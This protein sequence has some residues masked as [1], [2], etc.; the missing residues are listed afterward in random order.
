MEELAET[1]KEVGW[2]G[3]GEGREGRGGERRGRH[4]KCTVCR[5]DSVKNCLFN[6][7]FKWHLVC[8][9]AAWCA[10]ACVRGRGTLTKGEGQGGHTPWWAGPY[11]VSNDNLNL[12][13]LI[14][15]EALELV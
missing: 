13:L 14:G 3:A 7:S 12:V 6:T 5:T 15:D 9:C 11:S 10:S 2:A 4:S 1:V 8:L